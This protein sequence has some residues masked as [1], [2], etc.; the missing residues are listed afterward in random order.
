MKRLLVLVCLLFAGCGGP[1]YYLT[2]SVISAGQ[3]RDDQLLAC[4]DTC[5][6]E[7][8]F[9]GISSAD[10]NTVPCE[11]AESG[12]CLCI[13]QAGLTSHESFYRYRF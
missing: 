5:G 11:D 2:A 8:Y 12:W 7:K 9:L 3:E 1:Q 10:D 13:T 4:F 6:G